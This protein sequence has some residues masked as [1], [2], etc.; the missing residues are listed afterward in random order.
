MAADVMERGFKVRI[1]VEKVRH[2]EEGFGPSIALRWLPLLRQGLGGP[3]LVAH[4]GKTNSACRPLSC[5][6]LDFF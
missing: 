6:F 2:L 1:M 3:S 5:G 4:V